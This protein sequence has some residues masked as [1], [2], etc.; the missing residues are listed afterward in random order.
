MAPTAIFYGSFDGLACRYTASEAW[1][2]HTE[3]WVQLNSVSINNAVSE[4]TKTEF[5]KLFSDAP[6]LPDKAFKS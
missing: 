2:L 4:L 5:E 3:Q 6:P 1:V